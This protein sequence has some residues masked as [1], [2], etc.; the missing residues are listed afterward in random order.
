MD[1]L[2]YALITPYSLAKSRTGGIIGRLIS[3]AEADFVGARMYCPSDAFTDEYLA[4]QERAKIRAPF[5]RAFRDYIDVYFRRKGALEHGITNRFMMLLFQ[6]PRALRS[7][8]DVIGSPTARTVGNI[9]R[10]TYGDC[11]VRG[12]TIEYF[13][14]AVIT[15][16][17]EDTNRAHLRLLAKYAERD[18]GVL[19]HVVPYPD[20]VKPE[21]TLVMLKPDN[22]LKR[23]SRPGNIIDMFAK[24]GHTIVGARVFSMSVEQGLRFYGFL[25]DV[26]VDRLAFLV[27]RRLR[28]HLAHAFDFPIQD[29]DY[30]QMTDILKRRNAHAEVAKIIEYMTGRH[31]DG[32]RS[33]REQRKPGLNKCMAL[34][35][36]GPNAI[37]DLRDRLGP[38]DP[39]K[40]QG[41]TVRSDYGIDL[42]RN[43]AHASDSLDS[44]RRERPIVG[45]AG[46]EPSDE[47][48][49]IRSYLRRARRRARR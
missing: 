30:Q 34:L 32:V 44:A 38:T 48:R 3:Q 36:Q 7:L 22:F 15:A 20:K 17:D 26:F 46:G 45:L 42:M 31:P 39:A 6:G 10:G 16:A 14:P 1:Q 2:A 9:V 24:T 43:G 11:I 49:L 27:E 35:Y 28:R 25:E 5:K 12:K 29:E 37:A 8:R 13:E 41:G 23:S 4:I 19:E 33:A 40:A 18:G 47:A 21:T